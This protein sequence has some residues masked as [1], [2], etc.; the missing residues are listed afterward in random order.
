VLCGALAEAPL[1]A[2]RL[3]PE[4]MYQLMRAVLALV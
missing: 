3:S 2:M 1:L 4:A